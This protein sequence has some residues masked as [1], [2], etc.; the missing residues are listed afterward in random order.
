[1]KSKCTRSSMPSFF[2]CSTTD[3]KLDRRISGYVLSCGANVQR[4]I[5]SRDQSRQRVTPFTCLHLGLVSLLRVEPETF[6]WTCPAGSPRPLLGRSFTDGR[7]QQ[8]LHPDTW[9]VNLRTR[10]ETAFN[11]N[12]SRQRN[13]KEARC[14]PTF[15]LANPGSM[16]NTTPSMV[17]EVSAMFVDT[18]T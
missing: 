1:M 7:D 13:Q 14:L 4:L 9:I 3:P 15:C 6:P 17:R 16:T 2:S 8:R 12:L 10:L 11:K 5:N 18:T